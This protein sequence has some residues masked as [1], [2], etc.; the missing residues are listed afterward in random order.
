MKQGNLEISQPA[1]IS[2]FPGAE[3][4]YISNSTSANTFAGVSGH[5]YNSM[6]NL[7][8]IGL[9]RSHLFQTSGIGQIMCTIA[10][11]T[12]RGMVNNYATGIDKK[13]RRNV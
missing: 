2:M 5:G 7:V 11:K 4:A 9:L 8:M 10:A 12:S 13:Y 3:I 6:T 1:R